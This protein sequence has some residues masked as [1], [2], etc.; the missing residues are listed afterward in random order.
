LSCG[1][2]DI[3]CSPQRDAEK[4]FFSSALDF[5]FTGLAGGDDTFRSPSVCLIPP[6]I[7]EKKVRW[8]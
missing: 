6:F 7:G 4:I 3:S 5:F 8:V 2:D 1:I